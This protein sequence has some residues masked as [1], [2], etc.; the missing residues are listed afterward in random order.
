MRFV[1]AFA[2]LAEATEDAAAPITQAHLSTDC[3]YSDQLIALEAAVIH[4][5]ED[6]PGAPAGL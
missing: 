4:W 6:L 3:S 5:L 2:A 1:A